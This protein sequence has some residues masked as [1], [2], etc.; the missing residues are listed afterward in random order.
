M[1]YLSILLVL[2]IIL[3]SC[4]VYTFSGH[5]IAGIKTISIE[6][7]DNQ[8]AEFGIRDKLT[9]ELIN[10]LLSN[11]TLTVAN[12][13]SADAILRGKIVSITDLP[14]T[15]DENEDV[16]ESQITIIVEVVLAKPGKSEPLWQ[17]KLVGE[18]AYPYETGSMEE[19]EEGIDKAVE[20]LVQDLINRLTSDW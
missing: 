15:F 19:R 7:F 2:C 9:D 11:R 5:G 4:S 17:G 12:Q 18:G 6:P 16:K 20:R 3:C 10:E 13:A 8:T 14:L 1:K